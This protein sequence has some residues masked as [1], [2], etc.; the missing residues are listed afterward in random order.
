[1][2]SGHGHSLSMQNGIDHLR[3]ALHMYPNGSSLR[4]ISLNAALSLLTT[5]MLVT[6]HSVSRFDD[7]YLTYVS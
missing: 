6:S 2:R 4:Y 1:M 3:K 5:F 7:H